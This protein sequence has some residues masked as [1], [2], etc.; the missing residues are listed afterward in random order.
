MNKTRRSAIVKCLAVSTLVLGLTSCSNNGPGSSAPSV[1]ALVGNY[2]FSVAGTDPT[3]GDYFVVGSFVSDGKGNIT[4]AVADY[5]LGSGIDAK[6]PLT[7]TYTVTGGVATVKLTDGGM[8]QDSFTTQLV[9]TGTETIQGFDGNGS[10][11]LYAQVTSGFTPMGAYAY[12]VKGEGQGTV[13]GSGQLVVGAGNTFSAGMLSYMDAQTLM[14][15]P[16]ITGFLDT[17]EQGGRGQAALEGNN[18]AYYVVSPTQ[19]LMIGLDERALLL[20]TA[21]K[22]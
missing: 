18:L 17:P 19:V 22:Q 20:I 7:G 15:Y 6:V 8:V 9:T 11:T 2:V 4:S 14:T 10:G 12:T 16:S 21:T 3:D 5:N 1:G 13:T